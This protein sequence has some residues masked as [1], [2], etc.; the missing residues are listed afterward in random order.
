MPTVCMHC[1]AN[2]RVRAGLPGVTIKVSPTTAWYVSAQTALSRLPQLCQCLSVP[3]TQS[4]TQMHLQMKCGM[5]YDRSSEGLKLMCAVSVHTGAISFGKYS[6]IVPLR[7][8]K[9]KSTFTSLEIKSRNES[10]SDAA[11]RRR[12]GEG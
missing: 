5:C 6:Q 12:R 11:D 2:R 4:T 3:G 9:P 10:L 1:N 8:T 7:R